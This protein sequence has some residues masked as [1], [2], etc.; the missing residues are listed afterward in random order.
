MNKKLIIFIII[1]TS[2]VLFLI[3]FI[4]QEKMSN[5]YDTESNEFKKK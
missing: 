4:K 2:I 3:T 5:Q 1:I